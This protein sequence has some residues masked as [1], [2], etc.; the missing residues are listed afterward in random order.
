[1]P[2]CKLDIVKLAYASAIELCST[3]KPYDL[4]PE[5]FQELQDF[6][7]WSGFERGRVATPSLWAVVLPTLLGLSDIMAKVRLVTCGTIQPAFLAILTSKGILTGFGWDKADKTL[8]SKHKV[9]IT[10][11]LFNDLIIPEAKRFPKGM[12]CRV[13]NDNTETINMWR[14]AQRKYKKDLTIIF[15]EDETYPNYTK[16]KTLCALTQ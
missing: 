7:A 5:D 9:K 11:L 2:I 13:H 12:L 3:V 4:R 6:A 8:D 15:E 16:V 1:M 14:W 10:K